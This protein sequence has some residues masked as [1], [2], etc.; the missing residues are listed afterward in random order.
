MLAIPLR[1]RLLVGWGVNFNPHIYVQCWML[2][3]R[4]FLRFSF[5]ILVQAKQHFAF[6]NYLCTCLLQALPLIAQLDHHRTIS[7]GVGR[8]GRWK[9]KWKWKKAGQA[10]CVRSS[11]T[12]SN[13][14]AIKHAT[15]RSQA[16]TA[17]Q[18]TLEKNLQPNKSRIFQFLKVKK[19]S[20]Q[21][22]DKKTRT[23]RENVH[24]GVTETL[25]IIFAIKN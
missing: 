21:K 19:N 18:I 12:K 6:N 16:T 10:H 23:L 9:W 11:S 15:S 8:P 7:R 4:I 1:G 14:V 22:K 2:A 17:F 13:C 20:T 25:Q 5:R 3:L 24:F